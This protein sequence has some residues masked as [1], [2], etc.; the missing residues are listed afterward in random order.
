VREAFDTT[1]NS[2]G[3]QSYYAYGDEADACADLLL[4][5]AGQQRDFDCGSSLQS[6]DN[7]HAREYSAWFGRFL[8]VDRHLGNLLQPQSWNR[9]AYVLDNPVNFVDPNGMDEKKSGEQMNPGDTCA[10][11]S[12][13]EEGWCAPDDETYV[14]GSVDDFAY[15]FGSPDWLASASAGL[16]DGILATLSFGLVSGPWLRAQIGD[17][18]DQMVDR[19]SGVYLGGRITGAALTTAAYMSAAIPATLTH[20]TTAAGAAGIAETGAI[21][22]STGLTMF[23]D[24]VYATAGSRLLV[25]GA[26]TVPIEVSSAGFMRVGPF[27][28]AAFL[29]GGSAQTVAT[30]TGL[31]VFNNRGIADGCH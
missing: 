28:N 12:H 13:S 4:K 10:A 15:N 2:V 30:M 25:P 22:P 27:G 3:E 6:A 14:Y 16:G 18:T 21:L 9:Y 19:C 20:F 1:G 5:F 8:S 17:G 24:G 26:S 29:Q 31:A 11:G 7:L 23:G